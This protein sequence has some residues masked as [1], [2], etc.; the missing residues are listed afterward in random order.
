MTLVK[1]SRRTRLVAL[2]LLL[3]IAAMCGGELV[4]PGMALAGGQDCSGPGCGD[5]FA[6][7]Q[8]TQP[9]ATSSAPGTVSPVAMMTSVTP[10]PIDTHSGSPPPLALSNLALQPF[11]PSAPRSPPSA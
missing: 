5:Q 6:C 1:S 4:Q 3:A 11:A 2:A 9:Q 8:P 7:G 10:A